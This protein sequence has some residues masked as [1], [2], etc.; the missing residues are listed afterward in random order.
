MTALRPEDWRRVREVFEQAVTRPMEQRDA[1]V[2][3]ACAED[4][5][6]RRVIAL[7][8]AH[9]RAERFL[10]TPA[11]ALL[12]DTEAADLAGT[13]LGPYQLEAR[14]GAGGMGDVYR[15][16]D[17]RLDRV[18]AIKVL[19][20]STADD[21]PSRKRFEREA[22]AVA[23]LNHQH[24]CTLHDVGAAEVSSGLG[25]VHYLVMEFLDGETLAGRL[26]RG[27]LPVAMALDYA[28][29]IASALR[30][31]HV[32]GI[33][34]RDLKPGN[35]MVTA[36]GAK[37]LDFGLAKAPA[38]V[39]GDATAEAGQDATAPS[40]DLTAAGAMLGTLCYMAPEQLR[41]DTAD[42]RTDVYAF[43]C[44]LYEMLTGTKAFRR[45]KP[46]EHWR[47]SRR[48]RA[49]ASAHSR[50]SCGSC[51]RVSRSIVTR[52]L[53]PAADRPL[54]DSR[55]ALSGVQKASGRQRLTRLRL[56][57][58]HPAPATSCRQ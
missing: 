7:L 13:R 50:S 26:T 20:A 34:H 28:T 6:R 29:Q 42:A 38:F 39:A 21:E 55:R 14:I 27:A 8:D 10:E 52:C 19:P 23:A 36:S 25:H 22:R 15:A 44:V 41:G 24:I 45:S 47:A 43:G 5:L 35:I 31:A 3:E 32:S 17:C 9:P 2:G 16:R 11:T 56:S 46:Y 57:E 37:L 12:G 51:T 1:F 4:W 18:V 49:N 48:R 30:A 33:V 58:L 54:A 40:G 53:A